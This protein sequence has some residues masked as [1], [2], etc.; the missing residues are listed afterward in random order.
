MAWWSSLMHYIFLDE[1]RTDFV[2]GE[3]KYSNLAPLTYDHATGMNLDRLVDLPHKR[4]ALILGSREK[5]FHVAP[6]RFDGSD[7][8]D[9]NPFRSLK[10]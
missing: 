4:S 1:P 9:R 5:F 3:P 7:M 10:L 8:L 6:V 2:A